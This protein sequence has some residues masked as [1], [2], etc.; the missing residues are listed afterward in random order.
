MKR[1]F[2]IL[3]ALAIIAVLK[4]PF[5]ELPL[6]LLRHRRPELQPFQYIGVQRVAADKVHGTLVHLFTV[7]AAG[8]IVWMVSLV[9]PCEVHRPSAVRA[10]DQTSEYL[11]RAIPPLPAAADNLFLHLI[12]HIPT[13]DGLVS[14]LHTNPL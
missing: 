5:Q 6:I 8:E 7:G 11:C 14:S 2:T 10:L 12:K 9:L 4:Q 3:C 1:I 13:D